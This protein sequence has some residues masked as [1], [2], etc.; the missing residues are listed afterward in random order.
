MSSRWIMLW[1]CWAGAM[2]PAHL[3]ACR[4]NVRDLGFVDLGEGTYTLF[5]YYGTE[6]SPARAA[7]IVELARAT[8]RDA[9]L[10]AVVLPAAQRTNEAARKYLASAPA[11]ALP[12]AVLVS[13]EEQTLP[14]TLGGAGEPTRRDWLGAFERSVASPTR[15]ELLRVVSRAFA[16]VLLIEGAEPD[17]NQRARSA[18]AA[19]IELVRSRMNSLPKAISEPPGLVVL[20]SGAF[21]AEK[22]LLWSL[23]LPGGLPAQ[24]IAAVVYG[25][26]R[27][28]GPLMKGNEITEANVNGILSFIGADC[29]CGLDVSWTQGT[30]LPV[31]WD[32]SLH[33]QAAKSLGFDPESPLVKLEATRIL[34]RGANPRAVRSPE[35]TAAARPGDD[36]QDATTENLRA[37]RLAG[38]V[39]VLSDVAGAA[40]TASPLRVLGL[41]GAAVLVA[42][43]GLLAFMRFT[44]RKR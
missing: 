14:L 27:W 32:S 17:A 6:T 35:A 24:P 34:E 5:C 36:A 10:Q 3:S 1:L 7:Q 30:R 15:E 22:V 25:K 42:S 2:C 9:N 28:I 21:S 23:G 33:A 26:A 43:A 20:A 39:A 19:G 29:E 8:F 31:R 37:T 11:Q 18:I 13:P 4:Y 16:A 44:G 12:V 40:R 41:A 38:P